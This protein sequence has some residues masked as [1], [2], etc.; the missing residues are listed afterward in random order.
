M[1]KFRVLPVFWLLVLSGSLLFAVAPSWWSEV[2]TQII[3]E[4]G[5]ENNYAPAN[6][7]QL[8]HVAKMAKSYLDSNLAGGSGTA[9]SSLVEGFVTGTTPEQ[10][11][12]NYAPLN[13]GQL[14]AVAKPFYDRLIEAGY[15]TKAN[16]IERGLTGWT[17]DYP[18]DP[19]AQAAQIS[20][21]YA[22]ANLGQLKLVFSFDLTD[23]DVDQDGLPDAWEEPYSEYPGWDESN[24]PDGDGHTSW[25]EFLAG[26]DPTNYYS[27][28]GG[29]IVPVLVLSGGNNQL[30]AAEEYLPQSL[31]VEVRSGSSTG[32]LL[33][34]A[35]V[36]FSVASGSGALGADN[37]EESPQATIN[38]RTGTNGIAQAAYRPSHTGTHAVVATTGTVGPVTFQSHAVGKNWLVGKWKFDEGSGTVAADVSGLGNNATVGNPGPAFTT[39]LSPGSA[40]QFDGSNDNIYVATGTNTGRLN[41]GTGSFSVSFWMK[42]AS[43]TYGRMVGNGAWYDIEGFGVDLTSNA[44]SQYGRIGFALSSS[45]GTYPPETY[46]NALYLGTQN[47][48]NDNKWHHVVVVVDRENGKVKIYVDGEPQLFDAV[49]SLGAG[50]VLPSGV[51]EADISAMTDLNTGLGELMR[52]GQYQVGGNPYTG[53]LDEVSLYKKALSEDEVIALGDIDGDGMPDWW[54]S[55]HFGST[56]ASAGGDADGDGMSNLQEYEQE[57]DPNNYYQ[58]GS[59]NITP[60]LSIKGGNNQAGPPQ[61]YL[62]QPLT[63]EV[64]SGSASGAL[65]N[66]A[67]V[68][69]VVTSGS[70]GL[71]TTFGG[72]ATVS[73]L[74][75]AT[76]TNGKAQAY[77]KQ[78]AAEA[79]ASTITVSTGTINTQFVSKTSKVSGLWAE[80]NFDEGSGTLVGETTGLSVTGTMVNQAT[81]SQGY[82]GKGGL[83]LNGNP[84]VGGSGAYVTMGNPSDRGLD[85]DQGSFSVSLWL[86]YTDNANPAGTHGRRILSKGHYAWTPGYFIAVHNQGKISAGVGSSALTISDGTLVQTTENF[87]DGRWHHVTVT[88]DWVNRKARIYVDGVAR[89][90]EKDP[91]NTGGTISPSSP[92][93]LDFSGLANLSATSMDVPF[94]LGAHVQWDH[95]RGELDN[96]QI[97]RKTLSSVE[98]EGL[99]NTDSNSNGMPDRW[100]WENFGTLGMAPGDDWDDDGLSNLDEYL[101]GTNPG[102]WDSDYDGIADGWEVAHGLN[103]L[104]DDDAA[105]NPDGDSYSN[106]EEYTYDLDP[107]VLDSRVQVAGGAEH[108]LILKAD[109]TVWACGVNVDGQLGDGTTTTRTKPVK[110]TSLSGVISIAAGQYHSLAAKSDGTVWAWGRNTQGQLGDN[111]VTQRN[112]PVQVSSLSGVVSVVAGNGHSAA[113]KANG[114][115]SAWGKNVDG[116]VGDGSAPTQ[117]NTPASVSGLTGITAISAGSNHTSALKSD[118]TVWSWGFNDSGRL[119]DGTTGSRSAPVQV[120]GLTG[121][122]SIAGGGNHGVALKSD[123]TVWSWGANVY[124]QLG[125]GT[126][127]TNATVS[128]VQASG[129]TGVS[130]IAGAGSRTLAIKSDGTL[131][132]W[133]DNTNGAV[134]DG[135]DEDPISTPKQIN[136]WTDVIAIG[137]NHLHSLAIRKDGS[138]WTWGRT[139]VR[140]LGDGS[141]VWRNSPAEIYTPADTAGVALRYTHGLL[142]TDSGTVW[143]WGSN[144]DGRL[145]DGTFAQSPILKIVE[146]FGGV[147]GVSAGIFHNLALKSDGTV[148]SWGDNTI[149]QLGDGTTIKRNTP[150]Q[151]SGLTAAVAVS[152]GRTHSLALRNTGTAYAWGRNDHGQLGDGTTTPR[153]TPVVVSGLGG[154][155]AKL[156]AGEQFNLALKSNG[157]VWAWGRNNLRQLGDGTTVNKTTP[158]QVSGLSNIAA[159]AAGAEH[160][161]VIKSD[162]TVWTWG[163][164]TNGQL[165]NN[166]TTSV[167]SPVQASGLTSIVAIAGGSTHSLAVKADGT[168]WAWGDNTYG[169]LG[170][171]TTTQRNTPVQVTGLSGVVAV[172]A[173]QY[174]SLAKKADGTLCAWG[175]GTYGQ[176][177]IG[178]SESIPMEVLGINSFAP[179]PTV[180]ITS[181]SSPATRAIGADLTLAFT[182]S[183]AIGLDKVELYQEGIKIGQVSGSATEIHWTPSTWGKFD[184]SLV[185]V[186]TRGVRSARSGSMVVNVP[187]SSDSDDL[188]D[189][190][191]VK[192]FGG[193]GISNEDADPDGDLISNLEEFQNGTDPNQFNYIVATP[194]FSPGDSTFQVKKNVTVTCATPSV[195]IR[196]TTDGSDPT[197]DDPS[198]ASSG[199]VAVGREMILK[200]KAWDAEGRGSE[201]AVGHY[202]VTGLVGAGYYASYLITSEGHLKGWGR[203]DD[204]GLANGTTASGN[205]SAPV[206]AMKTSGTAS[207]PITNA[208]AI[209]GG[210]YYGVMADSDGYAWSFG[211]NYSGQLGDGTTTYRSTAVRVHKNTGTNNY[212]DRIV[213]VEVGGSFSL[214][215]DEDGKIWSWGISDDGRLGDG[216][217]SGTK[218]AVNVI[219]SGTGYPVLTG[220]KQIA[221]GTYSGL[222]IT[223]DDKVVSWGWNAY[224]QLGNGNNTSQSR[225]VQVLSGSVALSNVTGISAGSLHSLA[226][227]NSGTNVGSVVAWGNNGSGQLGTGS[228]TGTSKAVQVIKTDN[229]PLTN[230]VQVAAGPHHSLALD[231]S[232]KVWA[233]GTNAN[234]ELGD[235]GTTGRHRAALV[236][237]G[238]G[239]PLDR[240]VYIATGG[241]PDAGSQ[242]FNLALRDDGQIYSWGYSSNYALG[243][244]STSTLAYATSI[245]GTAARTTPAKP[246]VTLSVGGPYADVPADVSLTATAT[247]ADG[248]IS[249]VDFYNGDTQIGT[250]NSSPYNLTWNNVG[251]GNYTLKAVAFDNDGNTGSAT[252]NLTINVP[253]DPLFQRRFS[254]GSDTGYVVLTS[255]VIP[256][257]FQKGLELDPMGN[258]AGKFDGDLPWITQTNFSARRHVVDAYPS[259]INYSLQFQNPLA[260]FGKATGGSPMYVGETYRFGIYGGSPYGD[261]HAPLRA[262]IYRKSDNALVGYYELSAPIYRRTVGGTPIPNEVERW[263]AYLNNGYVWSPEYSSNPL[264]R[265]AWADASDSN[266]KTISDTYGIK[267][268]VRL[269]DYQ[270]QEEGQWGLENEAP[271][272]NPA[273]IVGLNASNDDYNIII[274]SW[275]SVYSRGGWHDVAKSDD[276]SNT[277]INYLFGASFDEKP[278][279][280]SE[281]IGQPNF[282]GEPMPSQ[283]AGKSVSELLNKRLTDYQVEIPNPENYLALDTSAELRS[284]PDLNTFI[285]ATTGSLPAKE[286][287]L[288]LANYVL[289]EVRLVDSVGHPEAVS[290][291]N[292]QSTVVERSIFAP[293]MKRNAYSTYLQKQGSPYEQ[294][295]LLVYM[296]RSVG[297]PSAYV[298]PQ[299]NAMKMIDAS[300]SRVLGFQIHGMVAPDGSPQLSP[301]G[302]G[303]PTLVPVNWPFVAAHID[304]K[305]VNIYPWMKDI[306][307]QEKE[308]VYR[309]L[310]E[311]YNSGPLWVEKFIHM[312]SEIFDETVLQRGDDTPATLFVEHVK[313]NLPGTLNID[314]LGAKLR[315]RKINYASFAEMPTPFSISG[316]AT[317]QSK[318]SDVS[319][320][321]DTVV[322]SAKS[323]VNSAVGV[324]TSEIPLMEVLD[325]RLLVKFTRTTSTNLY[326]NL[327][328][329]PLVST[330]TGSS[331]FSNSFSTLGKKQVLTTS[332]TPSVD[333]N[334]NIGFTFN[335]HRRFWSGF[336]APHPG[337]WATYLG[338]I[339]LSQITA[340][341]TIAAGDMASIVLML[342]E[343]IAEQSEPHLREFTAVQKAMKANPSV[344][345]DEDVYLGGIVHLMGLSY[346][347]RYAD[348]D[349]TL[350]DLHKMTLGNRILLGS[351]RMIAKT[352]TNGVLLNGDI[353]L[354]QPAFDLILRSGAVVGNWT[355]RPDSLLPFGTY[356]RDSYRAL[357][358]VQMSALEHL[359]IDQFFGDSGAISTVK[360]FQIAKQDS[361]TYPTPMRVV[362]AQNFSS[363]APIYTGT[364]A[365]AEDTAFWNS[366]VV[367]RFF[368]GTTPN[369]AGEYVKVYLTPGAVT[370]AKG[371]Y[372]GHGAFVFSPELVGALI[373]RNME[374]IN[375]GAGSEQITSTGAPIISKENLPN[376]EAGKFKGNMSLS[377]SSGWDDPA[378][379][380]LADQ[381]RKIDAAE[382][383]TSRLAKPPAAVGTGNV[384]AGGVYSQPAWTS[385]QNYFGNSFGGAPTTVN[386]INGNVVAAINRGNVGASSNYSNKQ[387]LIG[388]PV[389][390]ITGGFYI[391]HVDLDVKGP[392]PIVIRRNYDSKS[393]ADTVVGHGWKLSIVPYLTVIGEGEKIYAAEMDGSVIAYNQDPSDDT[394]WRPSVQDNPGLTNHSADSV[395]LRSSN[396]FRSKIER[397]VEGGEVVYR[398]FS[399]DGS[400]RMFKVRSYPLSYLVDH[401]N[402]SS[403]PDQV[404]VYERE[405]PYLSEWRDNRGNCLTFSFGESEEDSD[406]GQMSRIVSDSGSFVGFSYDSYR[407]VNE[408]FTSDGRRVFYKFDDF[409]DLKNVTFS[410]GTSHSYD[411]L[412][413][414]IGIDGESIQVST[415]LLTRETKSNGRILENQYDSSRRV[416]SQKATVAGDYVPITNAWFEY[417]NSEEI[418]GGLNGYTQTT[419][420][421]GDKTRYNY[422]NS[423]LTGTVDSTGNSYVREWYGDTETSGGAFPRSPKRLVDVRGLEIGMRYDSLGNLIERKVTGDVT[424]DN[425]DD[426]VTST[427]SYNGKNLPVEIVEATELGGQGPRRTIAYTNTAQPWLP[428]KISDFVGGTLIRDSELTYTDVSSGGFSAKGLLQQQK[429]AAGSAD[430][431]VTNFTYNQHGWLASETKATG[432]SDPAVTRT[433]SYNLRGELVKEQDSSGRS[434][435]YAYDGHGNRVWTEIKDQSG[436]L[437]LWDYKYYNAN[438]E[439]EWADGPRYNPED[440]VLMRYDG[441][442][443]PKEKLTWRSVAADNGAAMVAAG[444]ETTF[445]ATTFYKHDGFGNLKEVIDPRGNS[446]TMEYDALGRMLKRTIH[447]GGANGDPVSTESFRYEPGNQ[448]S[449]HVNPLGGVTKSYYTDTGKLRRRENAD[450]TAEEWRYDLLG[451]SVR[452][453]LTNGSYRETTYNDSARSVR[454]VLKSASGGS[455]A[456]E[457]ETR[458]RRGNV[459][460]TTN[461]LGHTSTFT[462]DDLNRVKS[463]EGPPATQGAARQRAEYIYDAAGL[464]TTVRSGQGETVVTTRDAI[465]REIS[466]QHSDA[467][468]VVRQQSFVYSPDHQSVTSILGGADSALRTTVFTD[469]EGREAIMQDG[470]GAS[471]IKT[472]DAAGNLVSEK[473]AVGHVTTHE[474]D[475]ANRL[476]KTTLAGGAVINLVLDAAGNVLQ[477]KMPG[478]VTHQQAFD[479][480]SRLVSEELRNG[481]SVTRQFGYNYYASGPGAGLLQS[482]SDPRGVTLTN[483]YDGFGRKTGLVASGSQPAQNM[484]LSYS[485]DALGALNVVEQTYTGTGVGPVTRVERTRNSYGDI[486]RE[487]VKVSGTVHSEFTQSFDGAG[488]RTALKFTP[489]AQGDGAGRNF[490][491]SYRGD[492]AM[493]KV[494]SGAVQSAFTYGS[495]GLIKTRTRGSVTHR[496]DG[497]DGAGRVLAASVQS[498]TGTILSET[499][500]WQA[501][502]KLSSH[503]STRSGTSTLGLTRDFAYNARG[504][505]IS[506]E[507]DFSAGTDSSYQYRFDRESS[508]SGL[509]LGIRTL[510]QRQIT[511]SSPTDL[512]P[513]SWLAKNAVSPGANPLDAFGRPLKEGPVVDTVN[514][515]EERASAYDASGNQVTRGLAE[516]KTQTITWDALGR[517]VRIGE[518]DASNNGFDFTA[519]YDG[520]GRRLQTSQTPVAGGVPDAPSANKT[521]S[522]FDPEV[523]FLEVGLAVNGDRVW[524]IHGPDL[525][526]AYGQSQGMGGL[527][528]VI[529]EAS[530]EQTAM[531]TDRMGNVVGRLAG[532]AVAWS[533]GEL[534]AY[535]TASGHPVPSLNEAANLVSVIGWRGMRRDDSGLIWVGARYYDQDGGRFLSTDPWGHQASLSLYDY[536]AGDPVNF[537]DPDGRLAKGLMEGF[538]GQ[539]TGS[540]NSGA[541]GVGSYVGAVISGGLSGLGQGAQDVSGYTSYVNHLEMFGGDQY[542]A[543]NAAWNPAYM[544][545]RGFTEAGGG[546][547]L[548]PHNLGQTLT[549]TERVFST[550]EGIL[551]TV[552]TIGV[553]TGFTQIATQSLPRIGIQT[554]TKTIATAGGEGFGTRL[555]YSDLSK[556][557]K[558]IDAQLSQSGSYAFFP[559][560]AVS[561]RQ[562]RTL[563]KYTGDEYS[564]FTRGGQR[565]V[566]RGG[567]SNVKVSPQMYSELIAGKYGRLSGHTHPPGYSLGAGPGDQPFLRELGQKQ[568]GIWG[569]SG[570][571]LYDRGF[572][573]NI[574]D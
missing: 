445:A 562:L 56:S 227:Q 199:T 247:D 527:L 117:R 339:D 569:D 152:A 531:I 571:D 389:H 164:N 557:I 32:G 36:T 520:L 15:D 446:T 60:V 197:P 354:V 454:R 93:E 466:V 218:K 413:E 79:V 485:Y 353:K 394:V 279:L 440:Y 313:K 8:K 573:W 72:T 422:S 97:Y 555:A 511:G 392:M 272:L 58:R 507:S 1:S 559:K 19:A 503:I 219:S 300:L 195:T 538:N 400:V 362:T 163:G 306:D 45:T 129:L 78:G 80:W 280:A 262:Y 49:R 35:P 192:H 176:L 494:A 229:S 468:G 291:T 329:A 77:Y 437:L 278:P 514:N 369:Q 382:A 327:V 183:S 544:A 425:S 31:S 74:N 377:I 399:D 558:G 568:S 274:G 9:V 40:L 406:Y 388:D 395:P 398:L 444:G 510:A 482:I 430:E 451:R 404:V 55:M 565:L 61:N 359:T 524:K 509:G 490:D 574:G 119:G 120:T 98:V 545:M 277:A 263:Q 310:P 184:L 363:I 112:S 508:P 131:W 69:F 528:G 455:L 18:W 265:P 101:N 41:F 109:G 566:I 140:N 340:S 403:T 185:S 350:R 111:S 190:W 518:R 305:W 409:G 92:T 326:L 217:V 328:L 438:G 309:Y 547:G 7:G 371:D 62:T 556:A 500:A 303:V 429:I 497:R 319:G 452:E 273:M 70:G 323:S 94:A 114:T 364:G 174:C 150:V 408:I 414:M 216:S 318:L 331:N 336:V 125:V 220:I 325:R 492:G 567:G 121:V 294:C 296:L 501:D 137:G 225:A 358:I 552:G 210:Y 529:E 236:M 26:T 459:I 304:G 194:T 379:I 420:A 332:V 496:I 533:S 498:G 481:S 287:A 299:R 453:V 83:L 380:A 397:V 53:L 372:R 356:H 535:G 376:V 202:K 59:T 316:S 105:D 203:Q 156:A 29:T 127:G 383:S 253:E 417:H 512:E 355:I 200:A 258:N 402:N 324:T 139:S 90:L 297:V 191:E 116:Q 543:A 513:G 252:E 204:G 461:A 560:N 288:I 381:I 5:E 244:G 463:T 169:Q 301:S 346:G 415:H 240:I 134:G 24:D 257:D 85:F 489:A 295:A 448:I 113:L 407:R 17:H 343:V 47:A 188:P 532:S 290:G 11:A 224:G 483:T 335:M 214:A 160:S 145:G 393:F 515:Y 441:A 361:A 231:A 178:Y 522:F 209:D 57:S 34:N 193:V 122:M 21:N 4:E 539:D 320:L 157:S 436:K 167:G 467:T 171:G 479:N 418:S 526:G 130:K 221:A 250:D 144:E 536:G 22:P 168:V 64:R 234:K 68:S 42:T 81:W 495:D 434:I 282:Q 391:D 230:I 146:G 302:P 259:P 86:K 435:G 268:S 6:L 107:N 474:Y 33:N 276:L 549:A 233:W 519:L 243:H 321:F 128:P 308:D 151:T 563:T 488:R 387:N 366:A 12:A 431:S 345:Q 484:S 469:V 401:D 499:L 396:V 154:S 385:I 100:E 352:G 213:D 104:V 322:I 537:G 2:G 424:G 266:Y 52:F 132:V 411:Y 38:V 442:G 480:S 84:V 46:P 311:G 464:V 390:I 478:S 456:T 269:V 378:V 315:P 223:S 166:S 473:D 344:S 212:L 126:T 149:G 115:V 189:W 54:E 486:A 416:I 256:L 10:I 207:V 172:Y 293:G 136:D 439:V 506:E 254:R 410:D 96:V 360:L 196:Y 110:I 67:P 375:G 14:K 173:G 39:S 450:G 181:P 142:L 208:V 16:L 228:Y 135:Y 133:G 118:G 374:L 307:I 103:P 264:Q 412:H 248:T 249:R 106:L 23:F 124:G 317:F 147:I 487:T 457:S 20:D 462:Y 292:T 443:R 551:G 222:A 241:H 73:T 162:G 284:H 51:P 246:V 541:Y 475:A 370:G 238:S 367:P 553:G 357:N 433:L 349:R 50:L 143:T 205:I 286:K 540:S 251:A 148:W 550:A 502:G 48:F 427:F 161:M 175:A 348:S 572:P 182:S 242:A 261:S 260:V 521:S 298:F 347:Q 341:A 186:D 458:D 88:W 66:N 333:K 505:L 432:T 27:Q 226:I 206:V 447:T 155:V 245:S 570:T 275:G 334:F 337:Y 449:Q 232:G 87:N 211:H 237:S 179:T 534:T 330:Y 281:I 28:P 180:S 187:F 491:F 564:L 386:A 546:S 470:N 426:T 460:S 201:V 123:G 267:I 239:V 102:A 71:A 235:G 65:L 525:D 530:S 91:S 368:S 215:L 554:A 517:L 472:Y 76:G 255:F 198:V 75:V 516:G 476:K 37:E 165:G 25:E 423:L 44:A 153:S 30:G 283:Y 271:S 270:Y 342:D 471:R 141:R 365:S 477:R 523:E 63:V 3:E 82:D 95:Y 428:T 159:I 13:I 548:Q 312:D 384:T 338:L 419:N 542:M 373:S 421:L 108:T 177:A 43:P 493:T 504:Q 170:D 351:S 285:T 158:F 289:N 561:M 314:D 405:R 138:I 89:D 99:Y 465:G